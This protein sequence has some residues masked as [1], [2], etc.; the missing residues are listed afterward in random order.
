M[1]CKALRDREER[2]ERERGERDDLYR[3][4]SIVIGKQVRY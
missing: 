3:S 1:Y 2:R 4:L